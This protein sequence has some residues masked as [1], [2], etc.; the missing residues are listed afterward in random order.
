MNE[1]FWELREAYPNI[2]YDNYQIIDNTDNIEIIYNYSIPSLE[3]FKPKIIIPKSIIKRTDI[4][5]Y[6]LNYLVFHIGVIELISYYK[7]VCAKKII[8]KCG[9]LNKDQINWFKKLYYNGL[10]EFLY[11]NN[12]DITMDDLVD[13]VIETEEEDF[14]KR[15]FESDGNLINIGGGKDSC[16]SLN[17][18]E[19]ELNNACFLMNAK[20]PMIECAKVAGYSDENIYCIERIIDK[21]KIIK[22]N[23]MGFLNGHIPI[24]SIIAFIS[25]LVAYLSGK[26]YI[27]LS[28]E[29]SA[30]ESYVKGKNINHQYS[31][32]F[33]FES[34]FYSYTTTYFS[35]DIKYF[36]LLRPLKELQIAYI[37]SKL[38]KYH[39]VFKSCNLGSKGENWEWCLNCSKCLFIYIILSPFLN[40]E[41]LIE[42]FGENLLNKEAL[43]ND[44][45][46]LIGDSINKPF[47]CVGTYDE[48]N[49]AIN[50]TINKYFEAHKSLPSLLQFYYNEHGLVPVD[51][52]IL[53][54]YNRENNLEEHFDKLVKEM[55][56][57]E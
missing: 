50:K 26:K 5:E 55:I 34:D 25:Y 47:E 48:I 24:S 27:V 29:E 53:N 3:T 1:K 33:E 35:N 32:S 17:I 9:Y 43:L 23:K 22:L 18:L 8:I 38:K 46:G 45:I 41:E 51:D 42:I 49:Y 19:N 30:N 13:F 4:D 12:I 6:F 14:Q 11:R 44:F 54:S 10:G 28:N 36:S 57:N 15:T 16:V 21:E 52:S 37:F 40:E 39:R 56:G 2:I 20:G 31:K 7:S